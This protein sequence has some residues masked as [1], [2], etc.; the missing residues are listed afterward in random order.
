MQFERTEVGAEWQ[1]SLCTKPILTFGGRITRDS[2][3]GARILPY[4][5]VGDGRASVTVPDDGGFALISDADGSDGVDGKLTVGE[6][7]VDDSVSALEYLHR[8]VL[9]PSWLRIDLLMLLL[10]ARDDVAGTVKDEKAS[11]SGALV[12]CSDVSRL[13]HGNVVSE[14]SCAIYDARGGTGKRGAEVRPR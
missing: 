2:L 14:D 13:R 5:G 3:S 9:D 6:C 7:L 4:D 12:E 1:T 11:A 8:I 10:R